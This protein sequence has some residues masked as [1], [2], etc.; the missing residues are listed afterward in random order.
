MFRFW[1]FYREGEWETFSTRE[2]GYDHMIRTL[3]LRPLDTGEYLIYE[4]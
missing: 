1:N 3:E 4:G 2:F